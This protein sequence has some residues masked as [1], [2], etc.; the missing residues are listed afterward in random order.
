M[1]LGYALL[2][3]GDWETGRRKPVELTSEV[4]ASPRD[5]EISRRPSGCDKLRHGPQ[6]PKLQGQHA[7]RSR[8]L[9]EELGETPRL[10][11]WTKEGELGY[12]QKQRS[13]WGIE[14][15]EKVLRQEVPGTWVHSEGL[16]PLWNQARNRKTESLGPRSSVRARERSGGWRMLGGGVLTVLSHLRPPPSSSTHRTLLS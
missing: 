11:G 9:R 4:K 16:G 15:Q 14:K 6:W 7:E 3:Y 13:R 5:Q 1:H 10:Q 8:G 2:I 12:S